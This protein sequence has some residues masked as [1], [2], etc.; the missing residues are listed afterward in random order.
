MQTPFLVAR[1]N[2]GNS[3]F[4]I[5]SDD[6]FCKCIGTC[7]VFGRCKVNGFVYPSGKSGLGGSPIVISPEGEIDFTGA[8]VYRPRADE[9]SPVS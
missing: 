4:T 6:A 5:R 8:Y 2:I 1:P 7:E 9:G 3:F